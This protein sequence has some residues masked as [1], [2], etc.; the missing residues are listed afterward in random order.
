[1]Y[2][3]LFQTDLSEFHSTVWEQSPKVSTKY[4]LLCCMAIIAIFLQRIS[5]KNSLRVDFITSKLKDQSESFNFDLL[6]FRTYY[7][8]CTEIADE[9]NFQRMMGISKTSTV[10]IS[11]FISLSL[12][13]FRPRRQILRHAN[14]NSNTLLVLVTDVRFSERINLFTGSPDFHPRSLTSLKFVELIFCT[15]HDWSLSHA[16]LFPPP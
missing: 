1:M 4:I 8:R 13:P 16:P 15:L 5:L 10:T 12:S 11:R 9:Y 2:R 6:Q 7:K 3:E 14:D